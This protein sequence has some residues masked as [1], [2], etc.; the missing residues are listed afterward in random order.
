[1]L[2]VG[3]GGALGTLVRHQLTLALP[4]T[5]GTFPWPVFIANV[6]GAF[7]L[8]VVMTFVLERPARTRYSRPFAGV[9]FCGGLTTFS[10]WTVDFALLVDANHT[11]TAFAYLFASVLAAFGALFLGVVAVRAV[12]RALA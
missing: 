12:H 8:G 2:A 4:V 5:A 3:A 9:G 1:V 11:G 6:G 7:V 10:T